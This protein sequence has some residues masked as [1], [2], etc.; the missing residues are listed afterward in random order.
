MIPKGISHSSVQNP[1]SE[2]QKRN[3]SSFQ[4]NI[5][6]IQNY[7]EDCHSCQSL[8]LVWQICSQNWDLDIDSFVG[9]KCIS[10]GG[11]VAEY[12]F[13]MQGF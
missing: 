3:I 13:A 11:P 10:I 12:L 2:F 8:L 4:E 9:A 1:T 6:F 7:T 5:S